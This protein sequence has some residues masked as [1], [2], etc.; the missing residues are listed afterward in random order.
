MQGK[1]QQNMRKCQC[2]ELLTTDPLNR[3]MGKNEQDSGNAGSDM[4]ISE[5]TC[6][7]R[8]DISAI[9]GFFHKSAVQKEKY[10]GQ[11][12]RS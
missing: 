3:V 4:L 8:F 1:Q 5:Q 9:N 10:H 12:C 7:T 11:I 6:Q 2:I